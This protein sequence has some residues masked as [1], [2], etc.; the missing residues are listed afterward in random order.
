MSDDTNAE[1]GQLYPSPLPVR[2]IRSGVRRRIL[3]CLSEGRAT[4]TQISISTN[5]RLPHTSAELKRLRKEGLVFS[6]EETGSRGA[7]LALSAS[8]WDTLRADEIA[9]IRDLTS[10]SPPE[11]ALGRLVSVSENNLLVA[12]VHRPS[13]GPIPIPNRPLDSNRE[14]STE[15]VWTWIEPRERK[16]RWLSSDTFLPVPPPP[17]EVDTSN[18]SSWGTES[19]VWGVQ[20]FRF[21]DDSES[22]QLASGSWFGQPEELH[23]ITLPSRISFGFSILAP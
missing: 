16:P 22:L 21:V 5:L 6:D 2:R 10:E 23:K 8:G 13:D 3:E 12:F 19:Q 14:F 1:E 11:G 20:R 4:V 18:I 15:D 7:C 9:R 17:R